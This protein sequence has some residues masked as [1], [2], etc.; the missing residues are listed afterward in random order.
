MRILISCLQGLKRHTVPRYEFWREYFINGIQEAGHEPIEVPDVDWAEALACSDDRALDAWRAKTWDAVQ[1]FVR[2]EHC[3]QP[4]DM[5]LAYLFPK[6]VEVS[7]IKELQRIG[8]PCVNFFCDNAREFRKIPS[9]F[10]PFALHWVPRIF[11]RQ[12]HAGFL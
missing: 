9:E 8:I 6:Q 10:R 3:R 7:A 1:V 2:R 12:C 5:F 4:I 11:M